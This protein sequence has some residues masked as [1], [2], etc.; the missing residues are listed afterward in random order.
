[1]GTLVSPVILVLAALAVVVGLVV[2]LLV[3][4]TPQQLCL[5]Q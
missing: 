1:V 3:L 5:E 2:V 4:A